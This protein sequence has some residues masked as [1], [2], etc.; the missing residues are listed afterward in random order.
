MAGQA[1]PT[2]LQT[3]LDEAGDGDSLTI[4]SPLER[5]GPLV[6]RRSVTLDGAGRAAVWSRSSPVVTIHA[7]RSALHNLR[8]EYTGDDPDA[9]AIHLLADNVELKN[10]VVRGNILGIRGESG[11]WRYPHQVYLGKLEPEQ[12]IT[13]RLRLATPVACRLRSEIDGLTV[14]PSSLRAGLHEVR[15][16]VEGMRRD[17]LLFGVLSI[18]TPGVRREVVVNAHAVPPGGPAVAMLPP[19]HVIWQPKDWDALREPAVKPLPERPQS[20]SAPKQSSTPPAAPIPAPSPE[21]PPVLPNQATKVSRLRPGSTTLGSLF[22]QP[23]PPSSGGESTTVEGP[24]APPADP[25]LP[26][27][28]P[29]VEVRKRKS[30]GISP[31]FGTPPPKEEPPPGDD[32]IPLLE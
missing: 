3:V 12:D 15:L 16:H 32:S 9:C 22:T 24:M 28:A 23:V 21:P 1:K 25:P 8:V 26:P 11:V 5:E 18:E 10:V 2:G 27:A 13:F 31:L 17:T 19:G 14:E 29:V 4:R 30:V 7:A 20:Q 6:L